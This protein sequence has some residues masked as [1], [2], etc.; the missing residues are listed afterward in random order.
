[1][2]ENMEAGTNA[3]S[4]EK[5]GTKI[6]KES[7]AKKSKKFR[8]EFLSQKQ[9]DTTFLVIKIILVFFFVCLQVLFNAVYLGFCILLREKF[10]L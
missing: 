2:G 3:E 5:A 10:I 9:K 8:K 1:M 4:D 7:D 6:N